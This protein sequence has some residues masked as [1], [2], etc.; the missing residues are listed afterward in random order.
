MDIRNWFKPVS[1]VNTKTKDITTDISITS[2][3][4]N[5]YHNTIEIYTDGS[6]YQNGKKNVGGGVGV[7]IP[8]WN[9]KISRKI[10]NA[11]NNIAELTAI[12]V[13]IDLIN[14]RQN[15]ETNSLKHI[16]NKFILY[17]DSQYSL[18]CCTKWYRNWRWSQIEQCY[19]K[20]R[21]PPKKIKNSKLIRKIVRNLS[22]LKSLLEFKHI[23]AHTGKQDTHSIGN[24]MADKL[25]NMALS[26]SGNFH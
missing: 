20:R 15:I 19:Y 9:I 13:A 6:C 2:K 18:N 4:I 8:K 5:Y 3:L 17:T 26:V 23:K 16:N 10:Q 12:I 21:G 25:A 22:T 14:T 1:I 7:Y 24:E 11:T